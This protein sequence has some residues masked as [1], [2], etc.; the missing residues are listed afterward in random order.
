MKNLLFILK[1]L[2][3]QLTKIFK[4]YFIQFILTYCAYISWIESSEIG[5]MVES[6]DG[7]IYKYIGTKP[8]VGYTEIF[9]TDTAITS[10][11][12]GGSLAMGLISCACI[13]MIVLIEINKRHKV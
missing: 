11:F 5:K 7:W 4:S 9:P 1:S 13:I 6:N 12:D 8:K 3:V 10:G 2:F